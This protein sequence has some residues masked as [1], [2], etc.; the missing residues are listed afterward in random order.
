MK[1]NAHI[2]CLYFITSNPGI[3]HDHA[4]RGVVGS[5]ALLGVIVLHP[6]STAMSVV[7]AF[8]GTA[9]LYA[10]HGGA[11]RRLRRGY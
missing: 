5:D 10:P 8:R 2:Y 1:C 6:A 7:R 4:L 3:L 9:P 11:R